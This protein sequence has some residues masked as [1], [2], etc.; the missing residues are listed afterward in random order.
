MLPLL[1]LLIVALAVTLTSVWMVRERSIPLSFVLSLA[2]AI[3]GGVFGMVAGIA[4]EAVS[5]GNA[6]VAPISGAI[7]ALLGAAMAA[8]LPSLVS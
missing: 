5:V 2:G 3:G 4:L 7:L 1:Y 6:S 8:L